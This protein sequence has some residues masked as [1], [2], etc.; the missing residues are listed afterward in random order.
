[1]H[2]MRPPAPPLVA[3]L[4]LLFLLAATVAPPAAAVC[5]PRSGGKPGRPAPL[6]PPKAKPS[7]PPPAPAPP[8]KPVPFVPPGGDIIK[9]MCLK[10]DYPDVC[11]SAIA[12]QP[13]PPLPG[14]K[15]LD[16]AGVLR[17]AM[18]AVRA[19]AAEAKKAAA[20]LV[21]DP[22]TPA[23]VR[24]ALKDCVEEYDDIPYTLDQVEKAMAAGD[25][26]KTGTYLDTARTD[27]DTCDQGFEDR[28]EL[29]PLMAKQDAM[30][31]KLTSNCLAIAS[32]AGLR[33]P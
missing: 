29:T 27:I 14:G 4:L 8:T 30:L 5:V 31:A 18:A 12:K 28:P 23:L 26:G 1:M 6:P 10:T 20:A 22:K 33:Y 2:A 15:R 19:A 25:K 3:C 16:G 11:F 13:P 9:S 32:A 7:P 21:A 17:L 24:G